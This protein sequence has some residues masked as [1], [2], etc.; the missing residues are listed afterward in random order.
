[1]IKNV[2]VSSTTKPPVLPSADSITE[3][4]R[5]FYDGTY[6]WDSDGFT[7]DMGVYRTFD[8]YDSDARAPT[9]L[10]PMFLSNDEEC[11]VLQCGVGADMETLVL[12]SDDGNE[13]ITVTAQCDEPSRN[14]ANEKHLVG[15]IEGVLQSTITPPTSPAVKKPA[16]AVVGN[17]HPSLITPPKNTKSKVQTPPSSSSSLSDCPSDLSEWDVGLPN[18]S[19]KKTTMTSKLQEPDLKATKPK[20]STRGVAQKVKKTGG[21]KRVY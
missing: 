10:P 9:P 14:Q 5:K 13:G 20:V 17:K 12:A 15:K 7:D 6:T 19:H 8:C 3:R 1:M 18:P 11:E 2:P 21:Y 16:T 4:S